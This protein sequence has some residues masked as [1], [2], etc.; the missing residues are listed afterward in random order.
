MSSRQLILPG[1]SSATPALMG[2]RAL[3]PSDRLDLSE[4]LGFFRRR[5]KTILA[6]VLLCLALAAAYSMLA[7]K[8][9]NARSTVM[10]TPQTSLLVDGSGAQAQPTMMSGELVDTQIEIIGSRDMSE[11]VARSLGLDAGMASEEK[12]ELIDR[13]R[14]N[15]AAERT[16]ESYAITI[17][18]DAGDPQQ[19]AMLANEYARQFTG[20]EEM[21]VRDRHDQER[22][23][24]RQRLAELREQA[25]ADTQALQQ[26]RIANNLLTTTGT[27]LTEQE[28]SNYNFEVTK[29]RAEAA[30][31]QARLNTAL[32]QLR[33]GSAGDD[34]GE[35]LESSVVASLRTQEAEV[36]RQ[37][38]N[39]SG[40]YG[41]NHPEL[42]RAQN[43]L[44]QIRSQIQAEIGRV[45][46]NL[47]AKQAVSSQRLASLNSSLSSARGKLSENNAAMVGLSELERSAVASQEIYETYLNRFK[48][49]VAA[50]GTEK[51]NAQILT[52]AQ[53]PLS[54]R[55][56]DLQLNL[57]LALVIGLG[58]GIIV[59]YAREALFQG[60][61]SAHD[62]ETKLNEN[63]L[64]SIPLLQSVDPGN[65]HAVAAVRDDPKS[66]F[67]ESFRAL[68]TSIS[69]ATRGKSQVIAITSALPGE[70]KTITACCLA[71]VLAT[72][73]RRTVLIDCDLRRRGISRL[74]DL[75]AEQKGLIEIL[76]GESPLDV[77]QLVG[78][79]VF[80]VIPLKG[81]D[82][83]PEQLL[84]G[85]AFV[86]LLD[87]LREH[88]D[89]IIL[90]L[91][92][93]LP[94][95][96]TRVLA[97]RADAVVLTAQWHKTSSFAIKAARKRL[98]DDQVNVVGVALNQ[99]D[100]RKKNFF[101]RTDSTYYY[102]QY[103]EY[104][105]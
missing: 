17:S 24:V 101:D 5:Y 33:S 1:G 70:G 31:D 75:R 92:P 53:A 8:T 86:R 14:E 50:E 80:C 46:S 39:M 65:P 30:E 81:S 62:V 77:E 47:R 96:S 36:A 100:L 43:E 71:H 13:L 35:A 54:P 73:G 10:L 79:R 12:R 21:S 58:L 51:P 105:S 27:S 84:T 99:V 23:D 25:Q 16:G 29:A 85:D 78:D 95:A 52:F 74:L 26:Y 104:Y 56:P 37:V 48:A 55:S 103:E 102:R 83:E 6:C 61:N 22:E 87:T 2:G 32:G 89:N 76:S 44:T 60:I 34:V 59:A 9:Y 49:L 7:P 93:V 18:V 98:P 42:R 66:I 4:S 45:I 68:H 19:A 94:M 57:A 88:F 97:S 69:Q 63:F 40:R 90:D 20:W 38:A 28:I 72:S 41:A 3:A 82:D 11:K 64:A 67:T 91:P 15:V